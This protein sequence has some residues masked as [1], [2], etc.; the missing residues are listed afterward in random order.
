MKCS[1][2]LLLVIFLLNSTPIAAMSNEE[3]EE[4]PTKKGCIANEQS[5]VIDKSRTSLTWYG[6]RI[7]IGMEITFHRMSADETTALIIAGGNYYIL[8]KSNPTLI[9]LGS[10][11]KNKRNASAL[12]KKGTLC[13]IKRESRLDVYDLVHQPGK[14]IWWTKK[15]LF[16]GQDAFNHA[17][18]LRYTHAGRPGFEAAGVHDIDFSDY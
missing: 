9:P 3:A 13:A 14:A 5:L 12:S 6:Q 2:E 10:L 15:C 18:I 16:L 4:P 7:N 1:N 11:H 8:T 17:G